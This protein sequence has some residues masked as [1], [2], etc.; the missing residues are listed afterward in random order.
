M[1]QTEATRKAMQVEAILNQ[2]GVIDRYGAALAIGEACETFSGVMA[3]GAELLAKVENC[4]DFQ[5]KKWLEE[6]GKN[7]R[8]YSGH[9]LAIRDVLRLAKLVTELISMRRDL[10]DDGGQAWL[11]ELQ[12]KPITD[13]QATELPTDEQLNTSEEKGEETENSE[14]ITNPNKGNYF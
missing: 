11:D 10:L 6:R 1:K 13:E 8:I 9:F 12:G 5:L 7:E 14:E 4:N 2:I 3:E